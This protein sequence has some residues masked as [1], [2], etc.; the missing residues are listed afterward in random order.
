MDLEEKPDWRSRLRFQHGPAAPQ[1][2][3]E[4]HAALLGDGWH[5]VIYA[6]LCPDVSSGIHQVDVMILHVAEGA[7]LAELAPVLKDL[8]EAGQHAVVCLLVQPLAQMQA[9]LPCREH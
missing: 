2:L 6:G 5:A 9:D 7:V 1:V 3:R 4:F 8:A